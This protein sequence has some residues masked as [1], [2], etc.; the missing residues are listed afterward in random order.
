MC[1]YTVNYSV[2]DVTCCD[3]T[4]FVNTQRQGFCH[5]I[6]VSICKYN[7]QFSGVYVTCRDNKKKIQTNHFLSLLVHSKQYLLGPQRGI[8]RG[9]PKIESVHEL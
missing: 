4:F 2:L 7:V 1:K 5:V 6:H 3:N 8:V 9:G